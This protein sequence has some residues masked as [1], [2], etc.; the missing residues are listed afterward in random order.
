MSATGKWGKA[1]A[2]GLVRMLQGAP[3][4]PNKS[5]LE[6]AAI[7]YVAARLAAIDAAPCDWSAGAA[8]V[9]RTYYELLKATGLS[10]EP[11]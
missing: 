9:D 1:E 8:E 6:Q 2:E 5:P 3:S 10:P 4:Y 7:D 11:E